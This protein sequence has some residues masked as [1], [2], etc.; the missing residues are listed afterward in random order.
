MI[1]DEDD[2]YYHAPP[3]RFRIRRGSRFSTKEAMLRRIYE[4]RP[5]QIHFITSLARFNTKVKCAQR[6]KGGTLGYAM[7]RRGRRVIIPLFR[8]PIDYN[9]PSAS[10]SRE[11]SERG[12]E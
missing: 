4:K 3:P 2:E 7:F 9:T 6:W 12:G 1:D 8:R 10:D 11:P 5:T